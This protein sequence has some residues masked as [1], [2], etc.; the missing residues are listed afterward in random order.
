MAHEVD[1]WNWNP[2]KT[3]RIVAE[4]GHRE[5]REGV[6]LEVSGECWELPPH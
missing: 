5:V 1:Q 2:S 3:G 6:P 4:C